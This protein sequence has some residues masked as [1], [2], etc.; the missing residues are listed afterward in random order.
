MHDFPL[1]IINRRNRDHVEPGFSVLVLV[2]LVGADEAFFLDL[3]ESFGHKTGLTALETGPVQS[4]SHLIAVPSYH[5]LVLEPMVFKKSLVHSL[6]T[7]IH[8]NHHDSVGKRVKNDLSVST[9]LFLNS[10]ALSLQFAPVHFDL[11]E[12]PQQAR[13]LMINDGYAGG[14]SFVNLVAKGRG[15]SQLDD[16]VK[17]F[18]NI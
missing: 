2:V 1:L 9:A 4:V 10:Q 15:A 12:V 17:T 11:D 8:A 13:G 3:F 16:Q 7:Q 5:F 14:S 6:N 18:K